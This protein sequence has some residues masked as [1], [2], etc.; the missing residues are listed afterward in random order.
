MG[1]RIFEVTV[2]KTIRLEL[3][4]AVINVVDDEWRKELYNLKTPEEIAGMIGRCMILFGSDLS[5]IPDK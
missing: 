4:D 2:S 1:K 3:D 5:G